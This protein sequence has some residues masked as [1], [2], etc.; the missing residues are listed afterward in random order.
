VHAHWGREGLAIAAHHY[1]GP[2]RARGG[3]RPAWPRC[4]GPIGGRSPVR[5]PC[6]GPA[7]GRG[8]L[9]LPPVVVPP[10]GRGCLIAVNDNGPDDEGFVPP[11]V[12]SSPFFFLNSTGDSSHPFFS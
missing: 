8:G 7:G 3:P 2:T 10:E 1:C 12:S 6:H 11:L 5:P 9:S 4:C